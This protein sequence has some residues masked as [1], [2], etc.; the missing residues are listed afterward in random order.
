M[1]QSRKE[2]LVN[3][4]QGYAVVRKNLR[5]KHIEF[6]IPNS[7]ACLPAY[8]EAAAIL[9]GLNGT[10]FNVACGLGQLLKKIARNTYRLS[11]R[12]IASFA[13]DNAA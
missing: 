10:E 6:G 12:F 4:R 1:G 2:T 13:R 7:Y 3:V 11:K 5:L 9:C 8:R